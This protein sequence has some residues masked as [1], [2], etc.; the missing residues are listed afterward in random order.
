MNRAAPCFERRPVPGLA[1]MQQRGTHCLIGWRKVKRG[2]F[3]KDYHPSDCRT[4]R[5]PG[6][7]VILQDDLDSCPHSPVDS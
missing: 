2:A 5:E 4:Q 3:E 1:T 6:L 7:L